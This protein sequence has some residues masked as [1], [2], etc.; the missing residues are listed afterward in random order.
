[1]GFAVS[2][3]AWSTYVTLLLDS[4]N[5]NK[6]SFIAIMDDLLIHSVNNKHLDLI[7][8]LFKALIQHGLKLSPKKSQL[9][10]KELVYMGTIF[11]IQGNS[12]TVTPLRSRIKAVLKMKPPTT[13]TEC[14][15]FCGMVNFVSMFCPYLQKY[16]S[17]IYHLT[18][19]GVPYVWSEYQDKA[20][21]KIKEKM[22]EP[23]IL[24]CPTP[25][26]RLILY[27]DTS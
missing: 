3:A 7:E 23:P 5:G 24:S 15:C 6:S 27:S 21:S 12:M 14:K 8:S 26:G 1:M 16:L 25:K 22:T 13:V 11:T 9:F 17:P 2:P 4:L 20:L 18:K 10:C 19:K